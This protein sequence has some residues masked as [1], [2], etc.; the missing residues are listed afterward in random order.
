VAVY[1]RQSSD[2]IAPALPPM[3]WIRINVGIY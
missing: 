3:T 2:E 1:R